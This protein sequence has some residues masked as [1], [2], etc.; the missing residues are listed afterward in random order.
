MFFNPFKFKQGHRCEPKN[1]DQ[2]NAKKKDKCFHGPR[3]PVAIYQQQLCK[4]YQP[5]VYLSVYPDNAQVM[6]IT[7]DP[8]LYSPLKFTSISPSLIAISIDSLYL[9]LMTKQSWK[10]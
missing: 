7:V 6:T 1:V 10:S 8:I 4:Y 9:F 5:T 2:P 3:Q